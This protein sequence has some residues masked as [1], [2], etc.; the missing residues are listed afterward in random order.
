MKSKWYD[1]ILNIKKPIIYLGMFIVVIVPFLTKCE[2]QTYETDI[3]QKMFDKIES[4]YKYNNKNKDNKLGILFAFDYGPS[5][6][7]ENDPMAYSVLRHIFL[8]KIPL[9]VWAPYV[10]YLDIAETRLN[11]I[12]KEYRVIYG[13]DYVFLGL[14]YPADAYMIS[15]GSDLRPLFN[16]DYYGNDVYNLPLLNKYYSYDSLG[17]VVSITSTSMPL[18]WLQY[19]NALFD[20]EISVGTTAVSAADFYPFVSSGQFQGMLAGL[21]GAAEYEQMVERLEKS[22]IGGNIDNYLANLYK[23]K[24]NSQINKKYFSSKYEKDEIEN[25]IR[26]RNQARRG[27]SSQ[28]GAHIYVIILILFGNLGYYFKNKESKNKNLIRRAR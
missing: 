7:P 27:M 21:K 3:S 1:K 23:N 18:F 24:D 12:A 6:T 16:N 22:L 13:R 10:P 19:A 25:A 2:M 17:L 8:R 20:Q 4:I 11:R 5:T 9:L 15:T 14:A 28:F 26:R